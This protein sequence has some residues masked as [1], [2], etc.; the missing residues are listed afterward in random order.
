MDNVRV[1]AVAAKYH[2]PGLKDLAKA[3]VL[4]LTKPK[5]TYTGTSDFGDVVRFAFESTPDTDNGLRD[6]F[7]QL[8]ADFFPDVLVHEGLDAVIKDIA[9]LSFGILQKYSERKGQLLER[10]IA[11]GVTLREQLSSSKAET[12]SVINRERRAQAEKCATF[13]AEGQVRDQV[14]ESFKSEHNARIHKSELIK[15]R[16]TAINLRNGAVKDRDAATKEKVEAIDRRALAVRLK[17]EAISERK[18]LKSKFDQL[19]KNINDWKYCRHT[20]CDS[21]FDARLEYM[22]SRGDCAVQLRCRECRTRHD[23]GWGMG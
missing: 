14:R 7:I 8:C 12:G 6:I 21:D 18:E 16:D 19:V 5:S 10:A 22:P 2:L 23:V 4:A 13:F 1:Y 15:E 11:D 20:A 17:D 9:S 3:R